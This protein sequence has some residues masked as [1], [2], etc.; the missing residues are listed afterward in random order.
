[1]GH[2]PLPVGLTRGDVIGAILVLIAYLFDGHTVTKGWRP[3]TALVD[4]IHVT[5]AAVWV[6]GVVMLAGLHWTRRVRDDTASRVERVSS[7][8]GLASVA[9]ASVAVAG[10]ILTATI[11]DAFGDLFSTQWGRVL[12]AKVVL[13]I[14]AASAGAYNHFRLLPLMKNP[15]T[16][17]HALR[18]VK[19][20]LLIEG[21]A[22]VS[23]A[24]LSAW[25]VGSSL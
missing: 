23:V 10:I 5:A 20:V 3:L 4:L 17:V 7:F 6:G 19:E 2:R 11:L 15:R 18:E 14:V 9:L 16:R 13:V 1:L 22:L 12:L 25:L 21:A 8:S 24:G